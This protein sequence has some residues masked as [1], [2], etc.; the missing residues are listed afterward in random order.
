MLNI[1]RIATY[2]VVYLVISLLSYFF[3]NFDMFGAFLFGI[4]FSYI[5]TDQILK[6]LEE[7]FGSK[8]K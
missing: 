8:K 4:L 5:F 6:R 3:G 1:K 7:Q 2:I